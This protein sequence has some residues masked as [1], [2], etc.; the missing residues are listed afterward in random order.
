MFKWLYSSEANNVVQFSCTF[1]TKVF[2]EKKPHYDI[3]EA[4]EVN[5]Q[6]S[7]GRFKGKLVLPY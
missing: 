5:I 2:A 4:M 7:F 6:Q 1:K 3:I